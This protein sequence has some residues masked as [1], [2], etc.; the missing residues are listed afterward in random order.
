MLMSLA[1]MR[2]SI[3]QAA[4][5]SLNDLEKVLTALVNGDVASI[6]RSVAI[7]AGATTLDPETHGGKQLLLSS[8]SAIAVTLPPA[9]G[10]GAVYRF[11]VS[12]AVLTAGAT[13][14]KNGTDVMRGLVIGLDNDANAVT[15][16]AASA[17]GDDVF[18]MN[19]TTMGGLQGDWVEF[20]D[21]ATGVWA[22]SGAV[23]IPAGS[24]VADPF[25]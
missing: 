8:D 9:T 17:A 22:V 19:A 20:T 3:Q 14:T 25:S 11:V 21:I 13:F 1:S 10:S 18:T 24:N 23:V 12:V 16:Y 2:A 15:G 4:L 7:P 5:G 6:G